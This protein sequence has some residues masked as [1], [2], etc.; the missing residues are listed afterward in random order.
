M[1]HIN[2]THYRTFSLNIFRMNAQELIEI[3][4]RVSDPDEGVRL[5]S[6]N[7][8]EAGQQIHREVNRRVHNFVAASLT[9]I[10]H[11]REF[12]RE[13]YAGTAVLES[14]QAKVAAEFSNEPIAKFVQDLRNYMLHRGLPESE[15]FL[16]YQSH[17]QIP[18]GGGRLTTGIRY[19]ANRLSAWDGW[20]A[21]A[22]TFI[23]NAGEYVD[24]HAVVDTYTNKVV[25]F[26]EWLQNELDRFHA[27]DLEQLWA[28]QRSF[29]E[30]NVSKLETESPSSD[31]NPGASALENNVS[32]DSFEF[33]Q[34]PAIAIDATGTELLKKVRK[35]KLPGRVVED[36]VSDR[37]STVITDDEVIETPL[38][39]G[40]DVENRRVFV[41]IRTPDGVFGLDENVFVELRMLAESVLKT[42]WA[43]KALSR[44]FIEEIITRWIQSSFSS[45]EV[46]H[47]SN[48]IAS[49]SREAVQ[50]VELWVPIANLEVQ[51]PFV[52]GGVQ[53]APITRA[54]IDALETKGRSTSPTQ[55]DQI[56]RLFDDLRK[57]MQG[58][59]AVVIKMEAEPKRAEEE[60]VELA[61]TVVGLLRFFSPAAATSSLLCATT[62]LGTDVVPISNLL[63]LGDGIFSFSAQVS[64]NVLPWR[65]SED[66]ARKLLTSGLTEVGKLV[67]PEGLS[68]F[69]LAV[70]SSL[71]LYS[72]GTTCSDPVDRIVYTLASLEGVLLK[73]AAEP[74]EFNMEERMSLLL[75]HE[76]SARDDVARN[77]REAYRLRARL[78]ASPLAPYEKASLATFVSNAYRVL[79]IALT[80]INSFKTPF[81]FGTSIDQLKEQVSPPHL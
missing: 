7:N 37:P 25:S 2:R 53:I 35:I 55:Q 52:I 66:A 19:R 34:E 11:T 31:F 6:Q 8:R 58:L 48:V 28:L 70:R 74:A 43:A 62:L 39:W 41:F 18:D 3:T 72:T 46:S 9:L 79:C 20:T 75:A 68:A 64:G 80:N 63:V 16:N 81:E 56:E 24:I 67:R 10:A 12:M 17:P 15:M 5:M 23:E 38:F 42:S 73:H 29:A 22:R 76:G 13:Q 60:G 21:P 61:R 77:V 14:Y 59:A 57:Q 47:L 27:E 40:T 49:E 4:R 54:M 69:A 44:T 51:A 1:A 71:L 32:D 65:I 30:L 50:A 78:G 26:H 36:F 45:T 33:A